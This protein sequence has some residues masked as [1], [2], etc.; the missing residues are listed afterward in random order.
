MRF[1]LATVLVLCA[2]EV[3]AAGDIDR[4]RDRRPSAPADLPR[5]VF[6]AFDASR[7]EHHRR[8]ALGH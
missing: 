8:A 2:L 1:V 4:A 7:A 3:R 5:D 6:E